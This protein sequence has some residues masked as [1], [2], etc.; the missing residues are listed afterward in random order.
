MLDPIKLHHLLNKAQKN[1]THL[2]VSDLSKGGH[3]EW[4]KEI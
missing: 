1:H 3:S 2:P 4:N